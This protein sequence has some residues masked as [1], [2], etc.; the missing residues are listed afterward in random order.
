MSF[1]A[2]RAGVIAAIF[3]AVAASFAL[4]TA[5][6]AGPGTTASDGVAV[7]PSTSPTPP[8]QPDGAIW[9]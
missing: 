6:V 3:L 2:R 7:A 4:W 5:T 1:S 8:A 9:G